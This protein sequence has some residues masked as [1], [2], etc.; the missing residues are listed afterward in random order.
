LYLHGRDDGC[1]TPAF[2][3]WTAKVLPAGSDVAII[4]HAG[5]FLQ[6]ERPEKV[7]EQVL[8]FVG[9]PG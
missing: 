4:D 2:A 1:M 8:A 7:A 9:S 3:H 5:H 6:L